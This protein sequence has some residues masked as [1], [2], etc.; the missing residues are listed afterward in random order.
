[1]CYRPIKIKNPSRHWN[2]D[3]PKYIYVPCGQCADCQRNNHNEWFFRCMVEYRNTIN[4]GGSVLFLTLTYNDENLPTFTLPSGTVIK[5]FNKRHIHNFIKYFRI[6]L[7]KHHLMHT[8]MKYLICSEYGERTQR[9]HYHALI[10]LPYHIPHDI[11]H[12]VLARSWHYGFVMTS[13]LGWEITSASGIRYASKY[14]CKDFGFFNIPALQDYLNTADSFVKR[15]E[16]LKPYKDYLPKHWQSVHFGESFID[17]VINKQED[18]AQFLAN[19]NYCLMLSE[20]GKPCNDNYRI[21]RYYHIKMEK[22]IDAGISKVLGKVFQDT[23]QLGR[24]VLALKY[25]QRIILDMA[26]LRSLSSD[27]LNCFFPSAQ[28]AKLSFESFA[29]RCP[30]HY[31]SKMEIFKGDFDKL[32]SDCLHTL[33][34]LSKIDLYEF[35]VYRNFLR[36][37]PLRDGINPASLVN[38]VGRIISTMILHPAYPPE[39]FKVGL[40]SDGDE[41]AC[42]LSD[43]IDTHFPLCCDSPYFAKYEEMAKALDYYN[44][45]VGIC[46]ENTYL[47][48]LHNKQ[49]CKDAY[50]DTGISIT[51]KY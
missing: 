3:A 44:N 41:I 18:V 27:K 19:N 48:K 31:L 40:C 2:Y 50:I 21:P 38:E 28:Y 20:N 23:N 11:L 49:S 22:F 45:I 47:T 25:A 16:L 32:R 51:S 24:D 26:N 33:Y 13:K 1:M 34:G 15:K 36:F 43:N 12:D 14:V 29:K 10:Y 4:K 5:A 46:K 9:P 37:Y 6:L 35:S 7:K 42:P 39:F 17:D 8:D 30:L